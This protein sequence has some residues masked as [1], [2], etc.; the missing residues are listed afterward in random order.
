MRLLILTLGTRGDL[1]L[2]LVLARELRSRGH[3]ISVATSRFDA[4]R[5][6][7]T[8]VEFAPIGSPMRTGLLAILRD[9]ILLSDFAER[10]RLY[11]RRWLRPQL[12][13]GRSMLE[14]LAASADV[15]V[16]NLQSGIERDD[17]PLPNVAVTYDAPWSLDDLER[18]G[19]GRELQLV[20]LPK[21]LLDPN[22]RWPERFRFTGFWHPQTAGEPSDE[23][24]AF[25]AAGDPPVVM[26]LGS[27]AMID[28]PRLVATLRATGKRA[29]VVAGWASLGAEATP[30]LLVVP[31]AP[32]DWLFPRARCI[33]HHGGTGTVAAV[34]RAGVP[35]IVIPQLTT[36]ELFA[37]ILTREHL[38]AATLSETVNVSELAA[39]IERATMDPTIAAA[40]KRWR[41]LVIQ[42]GGV[43]LAADLIERH[44]S[45]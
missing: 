38:I 31:E 25:V 43:R 23:L 44:V 30:S 1:E 6:I 28:A 32:Y 34:M 4:D 13:A 33:I 14:R 7:E 15:F 40:V 17:P 22:N 39:A 8:G 20:A 29:V 18:Y 10:T 9:L 41:D 45:P 19:T 16:S 11:V 12:K 42:D 21:M 35:G 36:Q 5:V 37:E 24:R 26:T 3:H 27:M 2:F